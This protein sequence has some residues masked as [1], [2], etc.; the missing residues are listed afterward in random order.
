MN[1][2]DDLFD[3]DNDFKQEVIYTKTNY[4]DD[5]ASQFYRRAQEDKRN[6]LLIAIYILISLLVSFLG[7]LIINQEYGYLEEG[8]NSIEVISE[9]SF[10]VI[11]NINPDTNEIDTLNPYE[12]FVTGVY[13]NNYDK[14]FPVFN[15]EV[16]FF[17]IA[18][19]SLGVQTFTKENFEAGEEF[20]IDY[21]LIVSVEPITITSSIYVDAP[22]M[23]YTLISLV[24]VTITAVLFFIVDKLNFKKDWED[25]KENRKVRVS[26]IFTGF[27]L[28]YAS[29]IVANLILT[30]LGVVET[31]QNEIVIQSLFSDDPL[32]LFILFIVLCVLTP[33][34]EEVVFRKV[35]FNFVE[36]R[37]NYKVAIA[38]TGIIF[39]LMHVISF[40][41]FIQSI[42]YIMMGFVF[43]YI[44]W[45]S[46][47]NI[48]VVI[49]V[50][51]LNNFLSWLIYVLMI[52]GITF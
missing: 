39:G 5:H 31:S 9:V 28:V 8:I 26:N 41:D 37:S 34:V 48:Y 29:L 35:I 19:Q 15:V 50:H 4:Q 12:V 20:A 40:G 24:Q 14:V 2:Y 10:I 36:P 6:G 21:S 33:I 46:N 30:L 3:K 32:N 44:Y 45:K 51:F 16:E 27:L 11:D 22:S 25:F 13:I 38:M 7:G 47:K 52:Y 49:S 23:I 43:G 42:P 17:D 1:D 18:N